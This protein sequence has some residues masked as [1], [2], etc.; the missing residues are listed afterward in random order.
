MLTEHRV[1]QAQA[2]EQR[3]T[4]RSKR[5]G[6]REQAAETSSRAEEATRRQNRALLAKRRSFLATLVRANLGEMEW[7]IKL[8]LG[9]HFAA[10]WVS[11]H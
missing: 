11:G 7:H 3:G 2:A 8:F 10:N 5:A 6:R 9:V 4:S 1:A